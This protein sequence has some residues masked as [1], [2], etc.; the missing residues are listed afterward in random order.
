MTQISYHLAATHDHW[1][2]QSA[3]SHAIP[4]IKL[5]WRHFAKQHVIFVDALEWGACGFFAVTLLLSELIANA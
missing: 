1:F 3:T 4:A 5:W 2:D